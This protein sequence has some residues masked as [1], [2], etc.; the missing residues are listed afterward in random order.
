M[1][2]IWWFL[3]KINY[4]RSSEMNKF[5]YIFST[6]LLSTYAYAQ[7]D[8]INQLICEKDA[9]SEDLFLNREKLANYL[10]H[11]SDFNVSCLTSTS[12]QS[13]LDT[14]S[15]DTK[16]E[17][18]A[19]NESLNASHQRSV[20]VAR[21]E[22]LRL[23]I[24]AGV[25]P[26]VADDARHKILDA[27]QAMPS[28]KCK[29]KKGTDDKSTIILRQ[30]F[31]EVQKDLKEAKGAMISLGEDSEERNKLRELKFVIAKKFKSTNEITYLSN[32]IAF[33]GVNRTSKIVNSEEK[34]DDQVM[35]V[36]GGLSLNRSHTSKNFN[37]L[38][39]RQAFSTIVTSEEYDDSLVGDLDYTFTPEFF[40]D[41][42]GGFWLNSW[43]A[44]FH[45]KEPDNRVPAIKP[46]LD[47]KVVAG[48]VFDEGESANLR[49]GEEYIRVG[50]STG[51]SIA[52]GEGFL[53]RLNIDAK[54]NYLEIHNSPIDRAEN[55]D[56]S[57]SWSLDESENASLT[58]TYIK[59][60]TGVN[61]NETD[62]WTLG[63]S[64][65]I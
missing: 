26:L 64:Y 10:F 9:N 37:S 17:I 57:I 6:L 59:G 58:T 36:Q 34:S 56:I 49:D 11:F 20:S 42:A 46:L 28:I 24:D 1:R 14:I 61:L 3:S 25:N 29:V 7:T 52:G 43:R 39:I 44:A 18:C 54:Y 4:K 45:T 31:E 48:H 47:L 65:K 22:M 23:L 55:W 41:T 16:V 12:L 40:P 13:I 51:L 15:N 5:I 8:D 30:S 62:K 2:M 63:L 35:E 21:R 50:Y 32:W 27:S 38:G 60:R 33:A 19:N 53:P